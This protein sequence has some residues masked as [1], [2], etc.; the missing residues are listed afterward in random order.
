MLMRCMSFMIS[1][2]KCPHLQKV[3][4][5]DIINFGQV[6]SN[7]NR[8]L[9]DASHKVHKS[10]LCVLLEVS[11]YTSYGLNNFVSQIFFQLFVI[12]NTFITQLLNEIFNALTNLHFAQ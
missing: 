2:T 10:H 12:C 8:T 1:I 3:I 5:T 4:K 6:G 7:L 9:C 11:H